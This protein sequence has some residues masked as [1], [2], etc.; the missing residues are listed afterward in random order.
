MT[1]NGFNTLSTEAIL[2]VKRY[3]TNQDGYLELSDLYK[4]LIP[5]NISK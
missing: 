4:A 3:D 1:A 2:F 5:K